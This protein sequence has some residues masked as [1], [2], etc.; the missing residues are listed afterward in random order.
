MPTGFYGT[1]VLAGFAIQSAAQVGMTADTNVSNTGF[2]ITGGQLASQLWTIPNV[3]G[4]WRQVGDTLVDG[5]TDLGTGTCLPPGSAVQTDPLCL[6]DQSLQGAFVVRDPTPASS[7]GRNDPNGPGATCGVYSF[8]NDGWADDPA[9][10]DD[11]HDQC[12]AP[13]AHL[14]DVPLCDFVANGVT[15]TW[16][17]AP[18]EMAMNVRSQPTAITGQ[19]T[20]TIGGQTFTRDVPNCI[21]FPMPSQCCQ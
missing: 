8:A 1:N 10:N 16:S 5:G 17:N 12:C 2:T 9:N 13:I 6:T 11:Y 18:E 3:L 4:D 14:C 20:V 7:V 15:Q 19:V 21:S